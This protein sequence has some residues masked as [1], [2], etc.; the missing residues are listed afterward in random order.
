EPI[1]KIKA[2][3]LCNQIIIM[4]EILSTITTSLFNA[5]ILFNS[6]HAVFNVNFGLPHDEI[7]WFSIGHGTTMS[8]SRMMI[9]WPLKQN[10][11]NV[12]WMKAYCKASG[13]ALPTTILSPHIDSVRIEGSQANQ[14]TYTRPLMLSDVDTFQR[15]VDQRVV[16]AMSSV[17]PNID[18]GSLGLGFHDKGYGSAILN[19]SPSPMVT[20]LV[21]SSAVGVN[22][23]VHSKRHDT[24][25]TLHATF[26]AISWGMIAPLAIVLARFLRQKGSPRWIRVHW[27]LQLIN[28]IFTFI[29]ILCAAFAVGSGSHHDSFQKRLGFFVVLCMLAQACGGYFIHRSA[30]KPRTDSDDPQP[31]KSIANQLHKLG[32]CVL[33]I[34]A[35][36][37]IVLGIKEWEFLGRGTPLAVSILIGITCTL[38]TLVYATLII[39]AKFANQNMAK[40]VKLG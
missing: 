31:R 30:N 11:G 36:V 1:R 34:T 20:G 9:M 12:Q 24:L 19:F 10:D 25:I 16:W 4:K 22:E 15:D 2:L 17:L 26:L 38:L 29:G 7:G 37:T 23:H 40:G 13:H 21:R 18:D 33:V 8:N 6:T 3:D 39:R 5:T 28:L 35:W 27:I 14:M 32:G